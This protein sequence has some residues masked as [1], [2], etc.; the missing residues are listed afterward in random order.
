MKKEKFISFYLFILLKFLDDWKCIYFFFWFFIF[1]VDGVW[2]VWER[3]GFCV[4]VGGGGL[5]MCR[6]MCDNLVL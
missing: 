4:C 2:I 6:C 1:I 5:C 3:W